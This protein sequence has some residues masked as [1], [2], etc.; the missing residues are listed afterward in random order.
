MTLA[1]LILFCLCNIATAQTKGKKVSATVVDEQGN[2]LSDVNVFGSNGVK[3]S[4][5]VN[6]KFLIALDNDESLVIQK[7]GYE[8]ELINGADFTDNII[9]EK[10][11]FLATED[12]EI[13]M[14]VTT[15]DRR[16]I[17]GAISTINTSERLTYDNTQ[18]VRNY[19]SGLTLGVRGSDNVRGLG[20]AVF[21]IDGVIG[22]D[23]N[24]LNI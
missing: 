21:V 11:Q 22:R 5:D 9:L 4:T 3:A 13:K 19:I 20:S 23:P 17:V 24:I 2:P 7:K 14:G 8:S 6:G 15:K 1:C 16:D 12:D 18:W 10:S